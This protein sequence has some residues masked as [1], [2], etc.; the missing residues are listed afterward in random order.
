[1]GLESLGFGTY[2]CSYPSGREITWMLA[3]FA[4]R[5][6]RIT[7]YIASGFD[8]QDELL[9]K[10]GKH[11]H[12]KSCLHIKRLSDVHLPTLEKLVKRSVTHV[13]RLYG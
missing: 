11:A 6:D 1:M 7:L 12:G 9:G 5:K 4:T 10:L 2:Q 8:G 3:A 13:R